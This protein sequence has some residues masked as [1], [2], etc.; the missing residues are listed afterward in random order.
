MIKRIF[1]V[2]IALL[3]LGVNISYADGKVIKHIEWTTGNK[4]LHYKWSPSLVKKIKKISQVEHEYVLLRPEIISAETNY[5]EPQL[6]LTNI[7][8]SF[9]MQV[10]GF[11][12]ESETQMFEISRQL[13]II[14]T[15]GNPVEQINCY[16]SKDLIS[17]DNDINNS[18]DVDI[19]IGNLTPGDYVA[20]VGMFVE[21]LVPSPT[22]QISYGTVGNSI[23]F[24]VKPK[25]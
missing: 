11:Y 10:L 6:I 25:S 9:H 16:N 14:P 8:S 7:K 23:K 24:V 12:H 20:E 17:I 2:V 18:I 3:A 4:E 5:D 15:N 1:A 13:C 19:Y 21:Q 22:T